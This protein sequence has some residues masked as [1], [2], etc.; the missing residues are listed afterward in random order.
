MAFFSRNQS[1][2]L[3]AAAGV[4]FGIADPVVPIQVWD[5]TTVNR[6]QIDGAL[7]LGGKPVAGAKLKANQ[8]TLPAVTGADGKF[9]VRRDQTVL[10]Q[11]VLTVKDASKATVGGA[12]ATNAE[13][14][15]LA[16]AS[17]SIETAF[18]VKLDQGKPALKPGAKNV[19]LTG[20]VTFAN[21][22]PIPGIVLWGYTLSGKIV[23]AK[24]APVAGV[25]ASVSD[26]EGQ[27]WSLSNQTETDGAY[28][29]RYFPVPGGADFTVRIAFG[30]SIAKSARGVSFAPGTS[31]TLDLVL[32]ASAVTVVGTGAAGAFEV[33][34]K[35]GAEYIGYLVGISDGEN[36]I[37]ATLSWPEA[38]GKFTIII[39][40]VTFTGSI[41][42][43]QKRVRFFSETVAAPGADVAA[44]VVP[45]TLDPGT[46]RGIPPLLSPT[47]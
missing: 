30:G 29:L 31:S 41:G 42:F 6:F 36:V 28:E 15:A 38:N 5:G 46:P 26:D 37:P 25:Y 10:D 45:K 47:A 24:G 40:D 44:N 2:R 11:T 7:S 39:P 32:D 20:T 1:V 9:S 8:F 19:T 27:T 22:T 21:G 18:T 16:A 13:I 12:A 34:E 3:N 17:F 33:K 23:D 35:T 43:F 4:D 14:D